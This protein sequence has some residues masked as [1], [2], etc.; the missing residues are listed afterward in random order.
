MILRNEDLRL[1]EEN[2]RLKIKDLVDE[3]RYIFSKKG[4]VD[5]FQI[6]EDISLFIR[7]PLDTCEL[8]SFSAYIYEEFVVFLNSNFSLGN[9]RFT[10][11]CELYHILYNTDKL[12]R[13]KLILSADKY[14]KE[15]ETA[16]VFAGEFL[17]PE[18][19]VKDLFHKLINIDKLYVEP[20]HIVRLNCTLKVSYE[21]MLKR[22]I[23]LNLCD[24]SL[25]EELSRFSSVEKKQEL[26]EI[27]K[28]EGYDISTITP[29]KASFVSKEYLE[30]AKKNYEE[31]KISYA[32]I[33][34]LL[35]FINGTTKEYGYVKT[36]M[37]N[38]Y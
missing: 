29:T 25:Y 36:T 12:K 18:E 26:R 24:A 1:P 13:E 15:Y 5:I 17:M 3:T 4:I 22:L 31:G 14:S 28:K 7:K 9:E 6:L 23:Q 34:E 19:Y 11:A 30:Y 21:I 10:A 37:E 8:S 33:T 16:Y 2:L 27:T 38:S 32:T 20:R 35:G